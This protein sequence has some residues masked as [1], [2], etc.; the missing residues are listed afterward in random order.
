MLRVA[1]DAGA[2]ST[3]ADFDPPGSKEIAPF[4]PV[5]MDDWPASGSQLPE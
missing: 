5:V 4:C 3:I 2:M 1:D